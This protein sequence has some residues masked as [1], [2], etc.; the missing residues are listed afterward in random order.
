MAKVI[1]TLA[2][3]LFFER[4]NSGLYTGA[5]APLVLANH[6]HIVA[7]KP[8][9][10]LATFGHPVFYNNDNYNAVKC[11]LEIRNFARNAAENMQYSAAIVSGKISVDTESGHVTGEAVDHSMRLVRWARAAGI[12][13]LID[14]ATYEHLEEIIEMKRVRFSKK[15]DRAEEMTYY[16]VLNM[17]ANAPISTT[18]TAEEIAATYRNQPGDIEFF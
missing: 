2:S 4:G 3:V 5:I 12:D 6:G 13:F 17:K 9:S 7:T 15:H 8:D 14:A 11:A 1:Q 10:I 16:S 18:L